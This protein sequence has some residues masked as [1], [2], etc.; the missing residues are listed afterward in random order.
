VHKP[1]G[2]SSYY[3]E[4]PFGLIMISLFNLFFGSIDCSLHLL[5]FIHRVILFAIFDPQYILISFKNLPL[6]M[7]MCFHLFLLD[8]HTILEELSLYW[9]SK[10]F[11]PI[12]AMDANGGE[13]SR[14]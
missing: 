14:V 11:L 8:M 9:P 3:L 7:C 6:Y 2:A 1:W 4:H 5:K 12:L 13:V 10:L